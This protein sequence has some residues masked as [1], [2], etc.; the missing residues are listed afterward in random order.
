M[1]KLGTDQKKVLYNIS[2]MLLG[3]FIGAVM[4]KTS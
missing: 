2:L 4:S 1:I 3:A